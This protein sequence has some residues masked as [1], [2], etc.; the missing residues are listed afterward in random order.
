MNIP[1]LA[2]DSISTFEA[3]K[4]TSRALQKARET[5]EQICNRHADKPDCTG[6]LVELGELR[7]I[8][9]LKEAEGE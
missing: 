3:L 8:A 2:V 6:V 9:G 5:A 4:M 1:V 7:R